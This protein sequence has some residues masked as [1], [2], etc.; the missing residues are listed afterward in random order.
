MVC[1]CDYVSVC[2]KRD[3]VWYVSVR[4][5]EIGLSITVIARNELVYHNFGEYGKEEC[6]VVLRCE[7]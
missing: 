7:R 1:V 5:C 4:E 2:C 3:C 6:V